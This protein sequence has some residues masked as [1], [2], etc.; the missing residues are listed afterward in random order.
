[1]A[2]LTGQYLLS[3]SCS[4]FT[5]KF[6][7]VQRCLSIVTVTANGCGPVVSPKAGRRL[8]SP[9]HEQQ[10]MTSRHRVDVSPCIVE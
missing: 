8:G 3:F 9:P 1:M 2:I 10:A 4:G 6:N 7:C 5:Y